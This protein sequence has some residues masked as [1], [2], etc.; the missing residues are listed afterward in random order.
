MVNPYTGQLLKRLVNREEKKQEN[1]NIYDFIT[2]INGMT[3]KEVRRLL[4]N[5][6]TQICREVM[7]YEEDDV[8]D[9]NTAFKELGADSL[10]IFS[11]RNAINTLIKGDVGVSD[12][13]NYATIEKLTNHIMEDILVIEQEEEIKK[14]SLDDLANELSSLLD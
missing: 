10:M 8:L 14:D 5:R 6:I 7:G 13:Y 4:R 1:N 12:F 9:E 2:L 3:K 11:M